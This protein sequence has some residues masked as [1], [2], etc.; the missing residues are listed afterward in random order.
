MWKSFTRS[1][2][3]LV[4]Y[5]AILLVF[6]MAFAFAVTLIF[7]SELQAFHSFSTS[8]ASVSLWTFGEFDYDAMSVTTPNAVGPLF[9]VYQFVILIF[10]LNIIVAVLVE[11][12]NILK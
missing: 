10:F 4:L 2:K 6:L 7:G 9:F 8:L 1:V 5:V 11:G 3:D 12:K